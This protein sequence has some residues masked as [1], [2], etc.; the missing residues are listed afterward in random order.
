MENGNLWSPKNTSWRTWV[1]RVFS[2]L[3][4][5]MWSNTIDSGIH[6]H[7]V[8]PFNW[9]IFLS[10][11][12]FKSR[13][14]EISSMM[15]PTWNPAEGIFFIVASLAIHSSIFLYTPASW[16]TELLYFCNKFCEG[17]IRNYC[18]LIDYFPHGL[19]QYNVKH[20]LTMSLL[21]LL[22]FGFRC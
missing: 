12:N 8:N 9:M 21:H 4:F 10:F 1:A 2:R 16:W 6:V 13:C 18:L 17:N 3:L 7:S 5:F 20:S 22:S 15:S 19:L 11:C 14:M